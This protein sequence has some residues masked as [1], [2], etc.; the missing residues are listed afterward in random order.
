MCSVAFK[1]P[2]W[3]TIR[4][5]PIQENCPFSESLLHEAVD[6]GAKAIVWTNFT[7]NVEWLGRRLERFGT[8]RVHGNVSMA[9]RNAG[10]RRTSRDGQGVPRA[11]RDT[12]SSKGRAYPHG[13]QS[14]H[15]YHRSFSLD[16]YLQAQD[17]IH[18][19]SQDKPCYV[20]N[21]VARDAVDEWVDMLLAAK[22]LAAQLG[23]G[24]ITREEGV[25]RR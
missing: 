10:L 11:Y 13:C 2:A 25:R 15:L 23:Q 22:H 21:L 12:R 5:G 24:D 20:E 19:I 9:S 3:S 17:R 16:D 6:S 7:E 1:I 8:A 18:R 4:I 14:C